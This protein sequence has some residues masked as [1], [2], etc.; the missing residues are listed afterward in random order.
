MALNI[1]VNVVEVD[2]AG[3]P[4][5]TGAAT[6]VAGFNVLTQRGIPNEPARVTSFAQFVERFGGHFDGG[7]GAYLVRGFFDNGGQTAYVNRVTDP[8]GAQPAALPLADAGGTTVVTAGAGFRGRPDPGEWGR[9]VFVRVAHSSRATSRLR[10][11]APASIVG[12][13]L[14]DAVDMRDLQALALRIDGGEPTRI[15]FAA[16]DF[17]DPAAATREQ[18]R[19][20][21]NRRTHLAT[22]G[23]G[24]DDGKSLVLTSTAEVGA[25]WTSLQVTEA[26]QRL[27]LP[28]MAEPRIGD[29]AE[30]QAGG[31]HLARPVHF[32]PGDAVV[33]GSGSQ[34]AH[35]KLLTVDDA[36]GKA[37]WTPDITP[38]AFADRRAVTVSSAEF[39]LTV[40]AGA[41]DDE[42]VVETHAGLSMESDLP[43][44]APRRLNHP[45]TGSRHVRLIDEKAAAPGRARPAATDGFRPLGGG[46]D[47]TPTAMHFAGDPARRTGFSAFD[48][49]E[50]QLIGCERT[51]RS[52]TQA[53][54]AYC[55]GRGDAVFVGAVPQNSVSGGQAVAYGKELQSKNAY[56]ALYGPWIVV[57][58]PIGLGDSPRITIPPVGH[59]MGVYARI[60]STRGIWKAPAGDEATL[61][62]VL[63]VETR[64]SD[65]DHTDL[66]VNGAVNGLRPVPRAGIVVDA[67]R[68]LSGDPRWRYVNVRLLF[69]FVKSSLRDGLR[70][71][72]QEPNRSTLWSAVEYGTVT[73]FLMGL[74]RQGAFGTGTP[75]QTFTVIVD[76]TNNP[77]DQVEQGRLNVEVYFYPSRPAETIVITVGQ[78]PSGGTVREA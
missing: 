54:L 7:L 58:D 41:G 39:T 63:D 64:L 56:G 42:H 17:P 1:G 40:A 65:A 66:V 21:I 44:Y 70:W 32:T 9:Q 29:P 31:T 78:Q 13:P 33:L 59:V 16:A 23:L 3:A 51:D 73:P 47:G 76:E 36:S 15:A 4:S 5:V 57:P 75:E 53:G 67:S 45:L 71:V 19:D 35:V 24:G 6:S 55:A 43:D 77:P 48:P 14:P 28:E 22:A 60:E 34:T 69:N 25:D 26:H 61:L 46:S 38:G 2:G 49:V 12:Q 18:I 62:G 11:A 10:E 30:L 8:V 68:T 52:I 20:A 37:T 74:W 72:R 27:G 50:V